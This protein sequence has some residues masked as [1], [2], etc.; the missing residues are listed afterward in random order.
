MWRWLSDWIDRLIEEKRQHVEET[1]REI[2]GE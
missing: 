1:W 2:R